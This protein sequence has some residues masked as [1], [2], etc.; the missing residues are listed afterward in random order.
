MTDTNAALEAL[1]KLEGD[2]KFSPYIVAP[3]TPLRPE[4]RLIATIRA[5]LQS[6][7]GPD[8]DLVTVMRIELEQTFGSRI[9]ELETERNE[10]LSA[11]EMA[12]AF[13]S[14]FEDDETQDVSRQLQRLRY[15]IGKARA[16]S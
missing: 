10:H 7:P 11:L 16:V 4:K 1:E 15:W 3:G 5:A 6:P 14:G 9:A 13:I 2:F 12:E 8:P